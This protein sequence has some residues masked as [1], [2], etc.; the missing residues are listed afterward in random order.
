MDRHSV[1]PA[2]Q[3]LDSFNIYRTHYKKIQ[4]HE[5]EVGMLIPKDLKPGLHPVFVR[6]HGG[7]CTGLQTGSYPLVHDNNAIVVSPNDRLLPEHNGNDIQEDLADFW[8]WFKDGGVTD[9]LSSQAGAHAAVQLDYTRVLAGGDSAGGYLAI[10]SGLTQP[11]GP[12]SAIIGCY[13]MT[14][15]LRRQ[16]E[17]MFM[18]EPSPPESIIDR[19]APPRPRNRISYA[20]SACGR[21]AHFFGSGS[22]LWP[23]SLLDSG[24][25]TYIPPTVIIHGDKDKAISID[26]SR[27]FAKS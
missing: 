25:A 9:Y 22:H 19:P 6:F 11:R 3:R 27:L 10:Q 20:L 15:Y 1:V 18:K 23:I 8:M 5:I 21:Y 17:A 24:A 26:D 4:D 7:G 16:Q 2:E 14:N 13:P 12:L